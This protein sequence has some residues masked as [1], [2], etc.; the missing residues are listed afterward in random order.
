MF[1]GQMS[2]WGPLG[3]LGSKGRFHLKCY[4]STIL[5]SMTIRLINVFQLETNYLFYGV[6]CQ[7]GVNWGHRGQKVSFT[8][9][10]LTRPYYIHHDHKTH[11]CSSAW[12][13]LPMIWVK[14]KSGVIWG[15]RSQKVIFSKMLLLLQN[16]WYYLLYVTKC[17]HVTMLLINMH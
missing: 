4:N 12:D 5:H 15:H 10:V 16:T 17:I 3:S 14:Y 8:K 2:I 6:K 13:P 11:T 1:W 7:S 9:N